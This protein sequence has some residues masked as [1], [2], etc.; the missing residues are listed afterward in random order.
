MK[1]AKYVPC[2]RTI[3]C[4]LH[5]RSL[6]SC[7][8]P[9]LSHRTTKRHPLDMN[10][11]TRHQPTTRGLV[12]R[13]RRFPQLALKQNPAARLLSLLTIPLLWPLVALADFLVWRKVRAALGGRQKLIVSG[14]SALPKFLE[15]FYEAAG[16]PVVSGYGLS[17]TSPGACMCI[18]GADDRW[19][20]GSSYANFTSYQLTHPPPLTPSHTQTLHGTT[21]NAVIAVRRA[22]RNLVDGG[23]VGL[24]PQEV[25]LQIRDPETGAP[26][27]AGKP[28]KA[29]GEERGGEMVECFAAKTWTGFVRLSC[30]NH[31]PTYITTLPIYRHARH[32][33]HP[34]AAGD[35]GLLQGWPRHC[36]GFGGGRLVQHRGFGLLESWHG[37]L[38][39]DGCV[40]G[41]LDVCTRGKGG[42]VCVLGNTLEVQS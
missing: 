29:R 40:C 36:Q 4:I 14:G 8:V 18:M 33:V 9:V 12:V 25:D 2:A 35:A 21:R 27:P 38:G 16:I 20:D 30:S 7:P 19:G 1:R 37:G 31:Q 24:P 23:V 10:K 22:D 26:L 42:G 11:Y 28:K 34:R 3:C 6:L 41:C 39:L 13:R 5:V 15:R 17:E 32:R